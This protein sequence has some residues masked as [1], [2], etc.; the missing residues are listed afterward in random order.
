M[1]MLIIIDDKTTCN[2]AS[3]CSWAFNEAIGSLSKLGYSS[4]SDFCRMHKATVICSC[5]SFTPN[6][7]PASL[8]Q[9]GLDEVTKTLPKIFGKFIWGECAGNG[10]TKWNFAFWGCLIVSSLNVVHILR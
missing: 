9:L 8:C 10:I 5:V 2:Q 1:L 7:Y 4:G 6:C 3:S